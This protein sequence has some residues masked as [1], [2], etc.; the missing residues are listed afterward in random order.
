MNDGGAV[1]PSFS[2]AGVDEVGRGALAGP[3]VAAA[4]V[5]DLRDVPEGIRD[6]KLLSAGRREALAREI[7]ERALGVA[8]VELPPDRKSVV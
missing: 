2:E 5:L 6:S 4:V 1:R 3:V 7:E 8:V